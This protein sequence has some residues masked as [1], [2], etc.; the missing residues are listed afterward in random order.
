MEGALE[1]SLNLP[2]LTRSLSDSEAATM[3]KQKGQSLNMQTCQGFKHRELVHPAGLS[4]RS[5]YQLIRLAES[6]CL[7]YLLCIFYI[8]TFTLNYA[9]YILYIALCTVHIALYIL[10]YAHAHFTTHIA[11]CT[12]YFV[13]CTMHCVHCTIH[14]ALCA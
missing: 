8:I 7:L 2:E 6:S 10:H 4:S 5:I 1:S 11:L 3:H 12:S 9:H 14:I 13:H